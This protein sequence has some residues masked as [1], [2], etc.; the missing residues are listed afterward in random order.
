MNKYLKTTLV[1]L[2]LI[3]MPAFAWYF[4]ERGTSL[5]KAAM[6]SLEPK[7][8]IGQFETPTEKDIIINS[9]K[10]KGK[11]WLIAV[12]GS[13]D[14]R[15][16]YCKILT[17]L[18][19]QSKESFKPYIMTVI[20]LKHGEPLK[21]TSETLKLPSEDNHWNICYLSIDHVFPFCAE[22]FNL[23]EA[24]QDKDCIILL[25]ENLMVRNYYLLSDTKEIQKLI[26]EYPVFLSLKN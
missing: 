5:R 13:L 16:D 2:I 17:N 12:I 4:L 25:D 20:G 8:A 3:G 1:L 6:K 19:Q 22:A 11:R 23:R 26:R 9:E 10:L 7:E 24:Y 15:T 14:R 18:Y 21:A